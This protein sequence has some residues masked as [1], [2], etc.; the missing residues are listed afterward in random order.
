M[1]DKTTKDY[2]DLQQRG[3]DC[4][5]EL[6]QEAEDTW[7]VLNRILQGLLRMPTNEATAFYRQHC[8]PLAKW[9]PITAFLFSEDFTP[10]GTA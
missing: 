8:A 4:D 1:I 5:D 9:Q 6:A 3:R 10:S 2:F 7:R